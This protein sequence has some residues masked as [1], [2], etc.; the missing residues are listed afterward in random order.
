[1]RTLICYDSAIFW[2]REDSIPALIFA[3]YRNWQYK[4]RIVLYSSSVGGRA[5]IRI[6]S[7]PGLLLEEQLRLK[8]LQKQWA[9]MALKVH[10]TYVM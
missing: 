4:V 10:G 8:Y 6:T 3:A 9:V 5:A 2:R 1:M 7:Y